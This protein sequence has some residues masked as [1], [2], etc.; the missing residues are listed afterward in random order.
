MKALR[1]RFL[2]KNWADIL[3]TQLLTST[4]ADS[5][6][7]ESWIESLSR[8][9]SMLASSDLELTEKRLRDHTASHAI[10]DLRL[11]AATTAVRVIAD[12]DD[13]IAHLAE[14]DEHC[15]FERTK[16]RREFEAM[17]AHR[18]KPFAHSV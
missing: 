17:L 7:F 9:N 13:F 11:L 18:S 2:P 8:I 16:R 15:L 4:Q 12:F 14:A 5:Q 6:S 3:R 10:E 1:K